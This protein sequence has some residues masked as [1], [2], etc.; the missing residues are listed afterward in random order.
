MALRRTR[1]QAKRDYINKH[2]KITEDN[3]RANAARQALKR[4]GGQR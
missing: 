4:N 3:L 2:S 1:S